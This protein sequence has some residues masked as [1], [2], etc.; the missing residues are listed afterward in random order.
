VTARS[1]HVYQCAVVRPS[2]L[3]LVGAD[4]EPPAPVRRTWE[5]GN[6]VQGKEHMGPRQARSEKQSNA[7]TT[8]PRCTNFPRATQASAVE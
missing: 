5:E 6:E 2:P 7:K 3:R 8:H 4:K 1:Q